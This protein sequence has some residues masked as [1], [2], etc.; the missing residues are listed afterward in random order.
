MSFNTKTV[1]KVI[2]LSARQ[3]DYWDKTHFIKPSL[4]EA[5]GYGSVRLY[6]FEDLV[7]LKV[8][9]TL[10]DNGISLQKIRKAI[11]FLKKNLPNIEDP[12]SDLKFLTDGESIFILTKKSR[13]IIDTLKHGQLVFS[14]ALG[15][16]I[17]ALKGEVKSLHDQ[18]KYEVS[19]KKNKYP[20]ILHADTE[21]GG[22]WV[23]CPE[24]PGC[25]SQGDTVEEALFMIKEAIEGCLEVITVKE[26]VAKAS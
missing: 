6:S 17:T 24:I 8:A 1:T 12:L 13:E 18:K 23:E 16:I 9:K 19:V 15:A 26:R 2:G 5:A 7:R 14:V 4:K 11:S 10:I 25:A 21:D 3:I 20:V 22:Y